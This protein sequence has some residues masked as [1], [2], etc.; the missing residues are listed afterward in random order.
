M[1]RLK[2]LVLVLITAVV[3]LSSF[4]PYSVAAAD[5]E[6][7]EYYY[8]QGFNYDPETDSFWKPYYTWENQASTLLISMPFF[9]LFEPNDIP[10]NETPSYIQDIIYAEVPNMTVT[11]ALKVPFVCVIKTV[12]FIRVFAGWNLCIGRRGYRNVNTDTNT[13]D[14]LYLCSFPAHESVFKQSVCYVANYNNNC[15]LVGEWQQLSPSDYGTTGNVMTYPGFVIGVGSQYDIY[16]YGANYPRSGAVSSSS[17]QLTPSAENGVSLSYYFMSAVLDPYSGFSSGN[18]IVRPD[19]FTMMYM[20]SFTPKTL[21]QYEQDTQKGIWESIKSIPQAIQGFLDKM[22]NYLLYF[23]E[24]KPQHVNPF[25]NILTDIQSFF[26]TQ[27]GNVQNFKNNLNST[28]DNV[29]GYISSGSGLINTFLTGVPILS[30]FVIFFVVF[31]IVRK[32]VGR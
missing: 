9:G 6:L 12:D 1:Q 18:Y 2:K 10:W 8:D 28:L 30:A 26:N 24:T 17:W 5:E 4:V 21:E 3:L 29:V 32:V 20:S 31:A 23:Q 14:N 13:F 7:I 22:L 27:M 19:D 11:D 15:E 25:S 16:L